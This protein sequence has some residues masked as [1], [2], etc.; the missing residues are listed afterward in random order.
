MI[1][2]FLTI[3]FR[4]LWKNKG[5]AA[6]NIFGLAIGI[7]ACL[8][9]FLYVGYELNYDRWNERAD[10]TV[11]V[12]SNLNFAGSQMNMAVIGAA[13]GPDAARELPE[14][15]NWCR[16]RDRGTFLVRREGQLQSNIREE[17]VLT[18][19]STFFEVFPLKMVQ[20]DPLRCLSQPRTI[21]ISRSRAEKYFSSAQMALGQALILENENRCVVTAVYEDMPK[22]SHFRADLLI[23]LTDDKEVKESP[24]F[25]GSNNNFHTYLLLR[26]GTDKAAFSAKFER[27]CREKFMVTIQQMLGS[28]LEEFEKTGQYVRFELQNLLD[29]HLHSDLNVELAANGNVQYV[30]ILSAIAAFILLI[31]CIN[32]MNLATARSSMRAKEIGVRKT[33]GSG[34]TSLMG[35]FLTESVLLAVVS[36]TL[37]LLL[38]IVVMPGYNNLTDRE[39]SIPLG[40]PMFWLALL[41]GAGV[42]GLLAGSY[43]AFFLSAFNTLKVL[44]GETT[45]TGRTKVNLRSTLVVFQFAISVVLILSTLLVFKQMEFIQTKKLGFDKSQVIILDDA[46]ALGDRIYNLKEEMLKNSIFEAA[47]VSGFL[48]IPSNRSDQGYMKKRA[49]EVGEIVEMQRWK[50]DSDYFKTLGMELSQGRFF[51]P[52]RILDSNCV[53][54]NET[55]AKLFGFDDPI[56]KMIY[57]LDETP[58][59]A[60]KPEDFIERE[61]IG[62]MKD[63]HWASLR[64]NIGPL[65]F[66]LGK[67]R[68]LASFRYKGKNTEAAIAALEKQWKGM[69][70]EQPFGY[71]F[72]DDAFDRMYRAEMRVSRLA[73]LFALFSVLISCLG[74]FGLSAFTVEQRTKEIGIRKVLG[75]SVA[76]I[77]GLLA[78]DF[79]KLVLV[80]IVIASPIA[81]Y[82]MQKWLSDFAYRIEIQWW[83]FAVAGLAALSIAFL[84][85]GFQSVRAALANP[86][87]SLRSE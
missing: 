68:G 28:T 9:I 85:V 47:S 46:Y 48:P 12:V 22:N 72:L 34:R 32:F 52:A 16:M 13:V 30:W 84:T 15:Q 23:S 14:I 33:L 2:N 4:S 79:L 31:A 77:T 3:A 55:A 29:I 86:V 75:A 61:I 40:E 49:I 41:G 37:A 78:K 43:P 10:R 35:Q 38:A 25:W 7:A 44:K 87:K 76:G 81:Y 82:F 80:A 11:R 53:I 26:K 27:L 62:V 54:I 73:G 69:A 19:D 24:P 6:I 60:P 50:V 18:V 63:F 70:P 71:R 59:G 67:S 21:A 20:G 39:L 51:D 83:M 45:G 42:V 56:G 65:C 17:A 57:T 74:L 58:R 8:L 64:D 5:I 36:T 66:Q 1:Q